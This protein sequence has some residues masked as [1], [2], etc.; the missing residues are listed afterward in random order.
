[1]SLGPP[2]RPGDFANENSVVGG[3]SDPGAFSSLLAYLEE[4]NL[5]MDPGPVEQKFKTEMPVLQMDE[6]VELAFK[7]GRDM[8]LITN[9]RVMRIDVQGTMPQS[10]YKF[11]YN[12]VIF[13]K[14]PITKQY[15]QSFHFGTN[16]P[17]MW[18]HI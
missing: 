7:C 4:N 1:M 15:S 14:S 2:G 13:C 12:L 8:F 3:I 6:T 5:K 10:R 17:C 18:H 11:F 16:L 9:K